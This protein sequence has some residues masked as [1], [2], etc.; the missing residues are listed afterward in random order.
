MILA[1]FAYL[2]AAT[3]SAVTPAIKPL[4]NMPPGTINAN[5]APAAVAAVASSSKLE[6]RAA[7]P[8]LPSNI[9]RPAC[10]AAPPRAI[11]PSAAFSVPL[12]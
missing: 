4:I 1:S 8:F 3:D 5:A 7:A 12:V 11:T 6:F 10:A 2:N 9:A